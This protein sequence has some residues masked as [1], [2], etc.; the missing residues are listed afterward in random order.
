MARTRVLGGIDLVPVAGPS[1]HHDVVDGDLHA[2]RRA[3]TAAHLPGTALKW[4]QGWPRHVGILQ[5][6]RQLAHAQVVLRVT[7]ERQTR[8]PRNAGGQRL[9]PAKGAQPPRTLVGGDLGCLL[10][11]CAN[12]QASP[13]HCAQEE[14]STG[15]GMLHLD[16]SSPSEAAAGPIQA[17][18]TPAVSRN[19]STM[20]SACTSQQQHQRY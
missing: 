2:F 7:L 8:E 10:R 15:L 5:A 6:A 1:G 16:R 9:A 17:L 20:A 14:G 18:N 12:W 3:A 11:M 13:P 19:A 4:S